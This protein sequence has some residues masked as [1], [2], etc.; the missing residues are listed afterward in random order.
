V[1]AV[2]VMF[3][4]P[5]AGAVKVLVQVMSEPACS[6]LGA[7][8]GV[9]VCVA[10]GGK[11]LKT[12]VGVAAALGPLLVHTPVTVTSLPAAAVAGTV[13]TACTSACGTVPMLT[14][15]LLLVGTGSGVDEPAVPVIVTAPVAGTT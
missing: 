13:T 8:L 1:P 4:G 2:A 14:W 6:G 10:P 12:Q 9:H 5:V 15:V 7:G 3:S 11:P